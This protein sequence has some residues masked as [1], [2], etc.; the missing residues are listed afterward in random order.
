MS[1]T[2]TSFVPGTL[3]AVRVSSEPMMP[4]PIVANWIR[5]L[6]ERPAWCAA[7]GNAEAVTAVVF[8]KWRRVVGMTS[9]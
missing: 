2:P 4:Q 3:A 1:H 9:F 8:R 6:G 7:A 5:S